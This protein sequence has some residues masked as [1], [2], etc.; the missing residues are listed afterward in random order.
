MTRKFPIIAAV[1]IAAALLFSAAPASACKC[2]NSKSFTQT[3]A[4]RPL[5]VHVR[6]A[7]V[8]SGPTPTVV[9][10]VIRALKGQTKLTR[11]TM[12]GGTGKDCRVRA[13]GFEAGKEYVL[14]MGAASAE[15]F[16]LSSCSENYAL[17]DGGQVH[18]KKDDEKKTLDELQKE[19][20]KVK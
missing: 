14:A 19:L 10:E 3:S 20:G 16:H 12:K 13:K 4:E 9:F 17:V 2:K 8:N 6:A 7:K 11:L 18:L 15:P 1:A 5:V